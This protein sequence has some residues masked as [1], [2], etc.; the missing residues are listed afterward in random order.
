MEPEL[1]EG[2]RVICFPH[3][4]FDYEKQTLCVVC[5]EKNHDQEKTCKYFT[6]TEDYFILNSVNRKYPPQIHPGKLFRWAYPVVWVIRKI[7]KS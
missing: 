6:K 1:F 5:I 3:M 7:A 2:D 4:S